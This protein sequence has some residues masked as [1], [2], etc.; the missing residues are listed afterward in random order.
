MMKK[1]YFLLCIAVFSNYSLIAQSISGKYTLV[2]E[3]DGQTPKNGATISIQFNSNGSFDFKAVMPGTEVTDKGNYKI[4][5]DNIN[6]SFN[7]MEQGKQSGTYSLEGGTLI[8]P[9]KMLKNV[10]GSSTWQKEGT[11]ASDNKKV[12]TSPVATT[13]AKWADYAKGKI[14]N[15]STIDN[16][17]TAS[18]KKVKNNLARGYYTQGTMLFFQKVLYGS[19]V[20]FRESSAIA[21]R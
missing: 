4:S 8:L 10:K 2:K 6:I 11:T 9:F 15:Y 21:G 14:K 18:S 5:G 1:I 7:E 16:Y 19:L 3:S 12:S 20:C 17:A 13:V